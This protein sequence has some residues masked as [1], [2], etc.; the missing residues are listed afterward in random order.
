MLLAAA[1]AGGAE[2]G[3]IR[4]FG[5]SGDNNLFHGIHVDSS[6]DIFVV[7][8]AGYD[9]G[10]QN[11]YDGV[12]V[13]YNSD[14]DLQWQKSIEHDSSPDNNTYIFDVIE[15]SSSSN[16]IYIAGY[17]RQGYQNGYLIRDRAIVRRMYK[18]DGNRFSHTSNSGY[19]G[20]SASPGD[21]QYKGAAFDSN[22]NIC[23]AGQ[24]NAG[25]GNTAF[26][27]KKM[28]S[29]LNQPTGSFNRHIHGT[30]ND[31]GNDI[32][33]DSSNNIYIV[34][35]TGSGGSGSYDQ[36]IAK[37]NNTGTLQWQ[38]AIGYSSNDQCYACAIDSSNNIHMAGVLRPSY[39]V[40]SILKFNSSGSLQ[41]TIAYRD[42]STSYPSLRGI[43]FDS[44]GNMYVAGKNGNNQGLVMKFSSS[45]T[46]LW[47]NVLYAGLSELTGIA[48]D[49]NDQ[50]IVIGWFG[51]IVNNAQQAVVAKLPS[52]GSG[53]GTYSG[54]GGSSVIYNSSNL[55][56]YSL[57][58][59]VTT[60]SL[61]E[62]SLS[63][64]TG[65]DSTISEPKTSTYSEYADYEI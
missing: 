62:A 65:S 53:L 2:S 10:V 45:G 13:K 50:P 7:G 52:D 38:R 11:Y 23:L 49:S 21:L 54:G 28:D 61:T 25:S 8:Q 18:S 22:N 43:C 3:W 42:S 35:S 58:P 31:E 59:T 32:A 30:A 17:T 41:S 6:D 64:S 55:T 51:G 40:V 9:F 33:I 56:S 34:G 1:G 5:D 26:F 27:I 36:F 12:V 39:S 4:I 47:Q 44:S 24:T 29:V 37:Y 48:V 20:T 16:I 14:G 46:L 60:T 63:V 15:S 57:T 19:W